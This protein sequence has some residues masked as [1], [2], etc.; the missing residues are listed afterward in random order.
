M[1][2]LVV[3]VMLA[4]NAQAGWNFYCPGPEIPHPD[5]GHTHRPFWLGPNNEEKV[6]ESQQA[7]GIVFP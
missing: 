2:S 3:R 4:V 6:Y 7:R 5:G 1:N